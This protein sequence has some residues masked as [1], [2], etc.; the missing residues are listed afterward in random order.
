MT[1]ISYI[2]LIKAAAKQIYIVILHVFKL[3]LWLNSINV[4]LANRDVCS[5]GCYVAYIV[6]ISTTTRITLCHVFADKTASS[7]RKRWG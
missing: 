5:S 3:P 6:D 4:S 2:L 1:K 7:L